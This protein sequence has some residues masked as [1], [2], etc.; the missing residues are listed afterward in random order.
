MV[1][2]ELTASDAEVHPR[3]ALLD[4]FWRFGT[5]NATPF[6]PEIRKLI[7]ASVT[8]R[9]EYQTMAARADWQIL[10]TPGLA[11][12]LLQRLGT[13]AAKPEA[14]SDDVNAFA[15]TALELAE[16]PGVR[17]ISLPIL[18]GLRNHSD[19]SAAK[20]AGDILDRL[21]AGEYGGT[22]PTP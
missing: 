19:A 1:R 14:A 18:R 6:L 17:E 3:Y 21:E 4:T 15:A 5:T 8:A 10:S 16:V 20:F 13:A 2:S 9:P 7:D 11:T 12:A 22:F